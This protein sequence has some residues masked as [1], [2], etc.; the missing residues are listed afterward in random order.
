MPPNASASVPSRRKLREFSVKH[1]ILRLAKLRRRPGR[2]IEIFAD[3][4]PRAKIGLFELVAAEQELSELLHRKVLIVTSGVFRNG[5]REKALSEAQ[6]LYS[7]S[8]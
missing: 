5:M 3:F 2:P 6:E 1:G 8:R 7:A 4:E